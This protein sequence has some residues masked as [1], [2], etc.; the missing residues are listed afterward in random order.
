MAGRGR[1]GGRA[2][3]GVEDWLP[4]VPAAAAARLRAPKARSGAHGPWQGISAFV[5]PSVAW[6]LYAFLRSPDDYW[7]T[8]CTAIAVG[9][10][11]DTMARHGRR[12]LRARGSGV[13][14]LPPDLLARLTDRGRW[15]ASD[16]CA[17]RCRLRAVRALTLFT[18]SRSRW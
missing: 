8:V 6:S 9:G 14:A 2:V 7:A 15:G 5:T 10:D 12:A 17:A 11:T 1:V 18:R 16:A 13:G 4:L 3:A